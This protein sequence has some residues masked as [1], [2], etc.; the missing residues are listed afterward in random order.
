MKWEIVL[1][2]TSAVRPRVFDDPD[3]EAKHSL[4]FRE[5]G[6]LVQLEVDRFDTAYGLAVHNGGPS[7]RR[8]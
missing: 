5:R 8:G 2:G 6:R 3:E 1:Q 4:P 7:L